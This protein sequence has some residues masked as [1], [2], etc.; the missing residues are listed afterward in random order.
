MENNYQFKPDLRRLSEQ[1]INR[2]R[3]FEALME[4]H[5]RTPSVSEAAGARVRPLWRW[6]AA[7]AA[8]LLI[9]G[10]GW[11][12]GTSTASLMVAEYT[13][14]E[15]AYF[16][17]QPYVHPPLPALR[18]AK[19]ERRTVK[20]GVE[21]VL[22]FD[23][24]SRLVVPARAF[25]NDRGKAVTGPVEVQ[26]RE[27]VDYVDFFLSG[28]PMTYDS[29]GVRYHFESAGMIELFAEQNGQ[30][31]QLSPDHPINV[32]L[33]AYIQTSN[34]NVP[35][36][37]NVYQ[38]NRSERRWEYRQP[39][40]LELIEDEVDLPDPD[41][42]TFALK[43]R[44]RTDLADLLERENT[45]LERIQRAQPAPL[46]P[47]R[48][49]RRSADAPSLELDFLEALE[50]NADA[51]SKALHNAYD[52]KV[53]QISPESP[54]FNEN[55]AQ[56]TWEDF[57]L[58]QLNERDFELTL[59][60]GSNE[61]RIL[62]N[63]VLTDT[64][65]AA[66]LQRY[67]AA[68]AAYETDLAVYRA[69]REARAS[70][71]TEQMAR[72]RKTLRSDYERDL[73]QLVPPAATDTPRTL[74]RKVINRFQVTELGIWNCDYPVL[75]ET[76]QIAATFLDDAGTPLRN[77]TAYV[78]DRQHNS[79]RRYYTT[80][81]TRMNIDPDSEH[82]LWVV[83]DNQKIAVVS[84]ADF[85]TAQ[86]ADTPRFQ[87]RTLTKQPQSEQEIRRVLGF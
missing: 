38:L 25:L 17:A 36:R 34:V 70:Q 7:A 24:G 10:V 8:V 19:T 49:Q 46:P 39:D 74:R 4:A 76:Q 18:D 67:R 40:R 62:I 16:A 29:A 11:W 31:L 84:P 1:E 85:R 75:P 14:Q 30:R 86:A 83:T 63:P 21:Q 42:P 15:N 9:G 33:V 27:Y 80:M 72:E 32:E 51:E 37:Y 23:S 41:D 43:R 57:R 13:E 44:Y 48:P 61:L 2:H 35:P 45:E 73:A 3:D 53:W 55:A 12:F 26:Y 6:A 78:V 65:Y 87:L 79:L 22:E 66:A 82:L 20:A 5:R 59:I 81:G 47:V 77:H 54:P 56:I 52:G 60:N 69:E 28:I 64:E 58:E 50:E 71:L 68:Q